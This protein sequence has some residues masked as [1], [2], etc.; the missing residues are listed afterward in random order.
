[1]GQRWLRAVG[2]DEGD[3]GEVRASDGWLGDGWGGPPGGV[4]GEGGGGD[5]CLCDDCL[6]GIVGYPLAE[7]YGGGEASATTA[8]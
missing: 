3:G 6:S 5:R 8:A 4:G 1:M 7:Q 2:G